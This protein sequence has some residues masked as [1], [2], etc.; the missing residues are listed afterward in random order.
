V[1]AEGRPQARRSPAPWNQWRGPGRD[2]RIV[3][4]PAPARWPKQLTHRW[5]VTVG[6]GHSSP[7]AVEDGVFVFTRE[8]GDEVIRRLALATGREVWKS[9]YAAPYEMN[10]AARAHGEGPKSTPLFYDGW[11]YTL[12][13]SGILSCFDARSGRVRWRH[14]FS[15]QFKTTSPLYGAAMSPVAAN[16]LVIAHVGGVE[17]PPR[18]KDGSC[19]G[20]LLD[21]HDDGALNAFDAKTGRIRW[22]WTGDGPAYASPIIVNLG[23]VRQVVTQTQKMCVGVALATGKLLWRVPFTTPFDQNC[24]TPVAVGETLVFGGTQQPTVA[25]RIRRSNSAW[26]AEKV[27]ET[28]DV[29]LYMNTPVAVGTRLYGMSERQRGQLFCLDA[30]T[31]KLEW[32]GPGRFA[33]NAAIFTAGPALLVLTTGAE[34]CVYQRQGAALVEAARYPVAD[35]PT[36]ASPAIVGNRILVKDATALT[37]WELPS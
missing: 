6:I 13:I 20:T 11:L 10:P 19:G 32:T 4:F 15:R 30:G 37:L 35:S 28:R 24:V 14:E 27:W 16:G 12:G 26:I 25:Y 9:R 21:Q 7:L 31:G 34:L 33:D 8:G 5:K 18:S 22:R 29:T 1:S 3:G 23:G 17:H 36:W 2:G